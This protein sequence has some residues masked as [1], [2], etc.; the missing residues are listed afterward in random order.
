MG[1]F[2]VALG[3]SASILFL[4]G[5]GHAQW[6]YTNDKGVSAVAQYKLYVPASYR[7][8][9]VWIGPTGVGKPGLSEEQRRWKQREDA[10]R[11]IGAAEAQLAPHKGR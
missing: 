3:V 2:V 7:D 4:P 8:T 6:R 1:L 11:R 10:Y 9:A 5:Q